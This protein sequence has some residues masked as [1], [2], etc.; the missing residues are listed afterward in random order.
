MIW[1]FSAEYRLIDHEG[2]RYFAVKSGGGGGTRQQSW[3]RVILPFQLSLG[4]VPPKLFA[5]FQKWKFLEQSW[6][7]LILTS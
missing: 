7:H 3:K 1:P 6:Q 4:F 2:S 5:P